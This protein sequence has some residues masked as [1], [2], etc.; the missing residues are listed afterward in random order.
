MSWAAVACPGS[1]RDVRSIC[2]RSASRLRRHLPSTTYAQTVSARALDAPRI[3]SSVSGEQVRGEL[4]RRILEGV[5][6]PGER[7]PSCRKIAAELG[8]NTNTVN[9][10]LQRMASEGIVR[11]EPR[12]GTY[13]TGSSTSSVLSAGLRDHVTELMRRA[14][15]L[16]MSR[17]ELV[18]LIDEAYARVRQPVVAFAECNPADLARMTDLIANATGIETCPVLIDDLAGADR[19]TAFDLIV[20]P[21]FHIGEVLEVL[22]DDGRVV[23]LNFVASPGTLREMAT[24][25]TDRVVTAVAP[26]TSGAERTAGLVRTVFRGQVEQLVHTPG[27]STNFDMDVMVYVNALQVGPEDLARPNKVIR[28]DWQLSGNS[29]E[30]LRTR[31]LALNGE[32]PSWGSGRGL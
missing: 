24:L 14:A 32:R 2:S 7:L 23:E 10:E 22:E 27:D 18:A 6:Q 20:T 17:D 4:V 8:S 15:G 13:V 29:A 5:W 1:L 21:L 3:R 12:R 19:A 30:Q 9:R 31:V 28:I 25:S 26:T 11:S 16:G